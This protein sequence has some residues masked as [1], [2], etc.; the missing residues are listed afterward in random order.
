MATVIILELKLETLR[1]DQWQLK[2]RVGTSDPPGK[3]GAQN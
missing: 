1:L 2:G 3:K